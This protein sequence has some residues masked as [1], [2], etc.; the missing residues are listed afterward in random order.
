MP[1]RSSA[2]LTTVQIQPIGQAVL[3]PREG[4]PDDVRAVFRDLVASVPASHF[5]ASDADLVEQ[6]AQSIALARQAYAELDA[7]GPV[8]GGKASPWVVVLEKAHRSS[9]ALSA[10]LRLAPQSRTEA[11]SAGR[12]NGPHPSPY[13]IGE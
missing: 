5:R 12:A 4:M 11:K 2:A 10:R 7:N 9:V 3:R 13:E 8:V 1:R 6:F